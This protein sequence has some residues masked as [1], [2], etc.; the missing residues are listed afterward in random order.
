MAVEPVNSPVI[1]QKKAGQDL[2]PG[3]TKLH[4]LG[5][6]F[7]PTELNLALVDEEK[8]ASTPRTWLLRQVTP[9]GH[10]VVA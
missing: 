7:I 1:T 5:A 10:R 4:G 2:K 9:A 8:P 6:G 3:R